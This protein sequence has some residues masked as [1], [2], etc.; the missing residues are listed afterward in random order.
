M[1]AALFP[2]LVPVLCLLIA[3]PALGAPASP[4]KSASTDGWIALFNGKDLTGWRAKIRGHRLGDNHADTFRVED[5]LLKV[6][7]DR[8]PRFEGKFGH[9]VYRRP[10][11]H[12][13]LRLEYR[14]VGEQAPGGPAWAFR[15]SGVMI[16]GQ[17]PETMTRD[18]D[19]PVSIEVQFLGGRGDGPRST[20]NM[21]SP[22]THV[23]VAGQLITRHC[24]DS[25]SRTYDGNQWVSVEV[26]V[27]GGELVEH[28]ID[29]ETVL[30]YQSPQLDEGEPQARKLIRRGKKLLDGGYIYLQAESHPVEFRRVE[31]RQEGPSRR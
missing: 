28:V 2:G 15:N 16:H 26:V 31:L 13:R 9:L 20:A 25:R 14:F 8:Y 4:Q 18:Q 23:V 19:F 1:R 27:R 3:A 29:G 6:S 30:S 21:C 22:G 24:L 10:F 17:A 5:G 11:S 12:Y 7:Y